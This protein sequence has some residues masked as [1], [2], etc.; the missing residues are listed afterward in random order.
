[1]SDQIELTAELRQDVGKG[2][3]RRLRRL[4]DK[5]PGII[6][7]AEADPQALTLA[8]NQ[9]TKAME[10]EAFYSQILNIVVE[11]DGQQ[12]VVRDLQRHPATSKVMHIDFLR[13][14]ADKELQVHVPIHFLNEDSCVGVKQEGGVLAHNII[15]VEISCLPKDLPEFIEV[16]VSGL[17]LGFAIHLSNLV[18]PA[19]VTIV[20]LTHG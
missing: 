7:G 1:M 3:S 8:S 12:A 16:D 4:G 2:A 6:Y 15:E 10:K 5:V 19:G 9:L 17:N 18:L 14:S 13:V 11:G 20:A